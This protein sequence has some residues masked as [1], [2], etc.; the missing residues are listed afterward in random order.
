MEQ[1]VLHMDSKMDCQE[2]LLSQL[3]VFRSMDY[4]VFFWA[5]AKDLV[6]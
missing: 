6:A 1:K 5:L 3:K 2:F 4:Q